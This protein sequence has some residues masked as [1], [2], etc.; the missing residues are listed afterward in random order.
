[1]FKQLYR[2][3]FVGLMALATVFIIVPL[4]HT[5]LVGLE[6]LAG[7]ALVYFK[8]SLDQML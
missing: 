1:M 8:K 6:N 2:V 3:P 4:N 5:I 7:V